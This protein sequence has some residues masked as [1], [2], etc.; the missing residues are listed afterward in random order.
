AFGDKERLCWLIQLLLGSSRVLERALRRL[1]ARPELAAPLQRALG[2]YGPAGPA[3]RPG[4]L[5]A[6]LGP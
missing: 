2:D 4:Y 3:L 6:L 5:A 1:R